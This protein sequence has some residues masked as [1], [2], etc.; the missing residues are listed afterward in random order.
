MK[1]G[2]FPVGST[3]IE[4]IETDR[5]E[6]KVRHPGRDPGRDSVAFAEREKKMDKKVHRKNEENRRRNT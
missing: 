1:A 3:K 2:R 5:S 6:E 4:Q